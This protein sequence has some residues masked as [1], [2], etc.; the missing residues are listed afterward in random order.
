ML[1]ETIKVICITVCLLCFY[2]VN[3]KELKEE[4]T[5]V[6]LMSRA[7][8]KNVIRGKN[9]LDRA[10]ERKDGDKKGNINS[11]IQDEHLSPN[12]YDDTVKAYLKH[13]SQ[14]P[15]LGRILL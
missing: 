2:L 4:S 11:G 13:I 6:T 5:L 7:I 14:I 8:A 10:K 1:L 9:F 3:K 15:F 12:F